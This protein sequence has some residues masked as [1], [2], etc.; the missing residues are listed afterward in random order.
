MPLGRVCAVWPHHCVV[1]RALVDTRNR[2][3]A[4]KVLGLPSAPMRRARDATPP[5]R[6][7]AAPRPRRGGDAATPPI[8]STESAR[9]G[10]GCAN[11]QPRR[12]GC[13]LAVLP[14]RRGAAMG[15]TACWRRARLAMRRSW[16]R[17]DMRELAAAAAAAAARMVGWGS[18]LS[19][20]TG[21]E[22]CSQSTRVRSLCCP[23]GPP[24][25][26]PT[27]AASARPALSHSPIPIR[28]RTLR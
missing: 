22:L 6:N 13:A 8:R 23:A 1:G 11:V 16:T 19:S 28:R 24:A 12:S 2:E 21:V 25:R 9:S 27:H 3:R 4:H 15:T 7:A 17:W 14:R 20:S 10:E 5:I 26:T 18:R